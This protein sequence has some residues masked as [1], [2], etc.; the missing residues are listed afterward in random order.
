MGA[1]RPRGYDRGVLV[2]VDERKG[3]QVMNE[4]EQAFEDGGSSMFDHVIKTLEKQGEYKIAAMLRREFHR[5][6]A[7]HVCVMDAGECKE[8]G[9]QE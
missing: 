6:P 8:C 2:R 9:A 3:F 7:D 4:L 5:L 1:D